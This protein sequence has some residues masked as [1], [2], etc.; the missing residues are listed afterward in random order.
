MGWREGKHEPLPVAAVGEPR[1]A[2]PG[3]ALHV[4]GPVQRSRDRRERPSLVRICRRYRART[5]AAT[6]ESA[7]QTAR[8]VISND[9]VAIRL[10]PYRDCEVLVSA[11]LDPHRAMRLAGELL[12]AALRQS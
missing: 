1:P 12:A 5:S 6:A 11:E 9:N 8:A 10:V 7:P 4:V 2:E 3:Q